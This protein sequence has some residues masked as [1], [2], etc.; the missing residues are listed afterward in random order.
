MNNL[1]EPLT[2]HEVSSMASPCKDQLLPASCQVLVFLFYLLDVSCQ[3]F[4]TIG[5]TIAASCSLVAGC[6]FLVAQFYLLYVSCQLFWTIDKTIAASCS[7]EANSQFLVVQ[8]YLL[9][10][11][12]QPSRTIGQK[13]AASFQ[14]LCSICQMLVASR[15]GQSVR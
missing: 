14:L 4:R 9:D 12:C 5:Q 1:G 2:D 7:L 6:Q 3:P 13:I 8:F 10:A 11:S 15:S